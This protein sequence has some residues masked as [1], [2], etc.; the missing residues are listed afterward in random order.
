MGKRDLPYD[1]SY[2]ADKMWVAGWLS[3]TLSLTATIM[4]SL[5][6]PDT[7]KEIIDDILIST[8]AKRRICESHHR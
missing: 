7:A 4:L 3:S 1:K 6:I 2:S 8:S 5:I